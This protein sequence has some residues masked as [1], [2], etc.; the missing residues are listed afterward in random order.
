MNTKIKTN[1]SGFTMIELLMVLVLVVI[2]AA[3]VMLSLSMVRTK[4]NN[5]R[6]KND[7]D[8]IRKMAE[9]I[10]VEN[11]MVGYCL[12]GGK[13][14]QGDPR[15]ELP[16]GLIKDIQDHKGTAHAWSKE[17]GTTFCIDA[18]LASE[19]NYCLDSDARIGVGL[20][21]YVYNGNLDYKC[22]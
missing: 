7:M 22:Q 9:N 13:C 16:N 10:Y 3:L 11:S 5:S 20:Q 6:I 8:Q 18:T 14:V 1:N 15:I 12:S 4:A 17:G 21:C 19:E 2:L